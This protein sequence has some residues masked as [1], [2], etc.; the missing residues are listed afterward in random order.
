M[1]PLASGA[2]VSSTELRTALETCL[3]AG[4]AAGPRVT[5]L[6]RKPSAYA[7]SFPLEE[8]HARLEDGRVLELLFKNVSP[9]ALLPGAREAK[10]VFLRD[11]R[12]EVTAY[13]EILSGAGLGTPACLGAVVDEERG[14]YW[15]FLE[16]VPGVELYQV[17]ELETWRAVA[18][19]L[20]GMHRTL[21]ER[22]RRGDPP[23]HLLRHDA[24]YFRC[25]PVRARRFA[26]VAAR[27]QIDGIVERYDRVVE[28]LVRMPVTLLHGEFYASNVLVERSIGGLRICPVDWE[29]AALGPGLV[30]LAA[31]VSGGWTEEERRE[32]AL[33]YHT[34][35]YGRGPAPSVEAFLTDLDHCR[36]HLAMQW[37]G[38]SP[39]WRPPREHEQDWLG[40]AVRVANRLGI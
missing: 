8:V 12:R 31:L 23:R 7:T 3:R 25:W 15:L 30:D 18:A 40:E 16:D 37:L 13:L 14:R 26:P 38:W 11:P 10:P 4:A 6:R 24:E 1:K 22:L 21:G 5:D 9:N 36:L 2:E 34:A 32:L 20:A 17:G 35:R 39:T 33:A 27:R 19:W 29:M 28:R